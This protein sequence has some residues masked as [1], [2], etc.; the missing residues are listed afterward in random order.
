[1][2]FLIIC[3]NQAVL[4]AGIGKRLVCHLINLTV[5]RICL[6]VAVRNGLPVQQIVT[7]CC[8]HMGT[9]DI[10]GSVFLID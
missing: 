10:I 1:M 5:Y 3:L 8:R 4:A 2:C 7:F 6:V 9:K